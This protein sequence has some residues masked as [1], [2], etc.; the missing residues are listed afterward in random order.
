MRLRAF[1][2][3]FVAVCL[4]IVTACGMST[5]RT[6]A[7]RERERAVRTT[8]GTGHR[9]DSGEAVHGHE[10]SS[11]AEAFSGELKSE[12]S[13]APETSSNLLGVLPRHLADLRAPAVLPVKLVPLPSQ[14]PLT[15]AL[16]P[17]VPGR[18]PP[19]I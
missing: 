6:G 3:S 1:S 4:A 7:P 11:V 13:A 16:I 14:T 9:L 2:T 12:V 19:S 15:A 10:E 18:A 5:V 17:P 8:R